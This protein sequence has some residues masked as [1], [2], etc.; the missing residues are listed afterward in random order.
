MRDPKQVFVIDEVHKD[1]LRSQR[2]RAWGKHN[3]GGVPLKKWF[4]NKGRYTLIVGFN[5]D[6]FV[7]STAGLY[8]Q[9]ELSDEGAAG[10]VDSNT[11]QQ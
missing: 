11:F 3:S 9:N 2:R 8:L 10:T 6:R 5:I 1:K 4:W 7:E